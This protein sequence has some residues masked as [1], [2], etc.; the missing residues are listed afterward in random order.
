MDLKS[1]LNGY[2]EETPFPS[3]LFPD[4]IAKGLKPRT[5]PKK[6]VETQEE[7]PR[8]KSSGTATMDVTVPIP[9]LNPAANPAASPKPVSSP[10]P[11]PKQEPLSLPVQKPAGA[12]APAPKPAAASP[13]AASSAKSAAKPAASSPEINASAL[14]KVVRYHHL[15]GSEFLSLLGNSKISNK[16]YQ[17]IESN[18]NLTVKRLIEILDESP[19]TSADYEK[20]IIAVQRAAKLKEE[21]KAKLGTSK[22]AAKSAPAPASAPKPAP[23]PKPVPSPAPKLTPEPKPI[24][25]LTPSTAAEEEPAPV[26]K[27]AEPE[28]PDETADPAQEEQKP[29]NVPM[30]IDVTLMGIAAEVRLLQAENA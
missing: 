30:P 11:V 17:E 12:P 28:G 9:A 14:I 1:A 13:A 15:T 16:A 27:P 4:K 29:E 10:K 7:P 21:A 5:Q 18:P 22:S 8:T 6:V 20:L 26:P 23:E 25:T 19:L 3:E 24:P 2:F